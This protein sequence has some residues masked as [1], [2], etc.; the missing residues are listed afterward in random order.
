MR[1]HIRVLTILVCLGGITRLAAAANPFAGEWALTIPG[2]AAGWLGVQETNGRLEASMMWGWGSVEP[3]A[4]AKLE[5]GKL[6]LTRNH[7]IERTD[8]SGRKSKTT[9]TETITATVDGDT[10][11][12]VSVKPS[13]DGQREISSS[14][15]G[16]R[17]PPL[18]PA[19]DLSKVKFGPPIELFNGKD[20]S[21][22]R[23]TDPNAI[24][25]WNVKDGLLVNQV[26]QE[27]GKH[28]NYGNLR[29]DAEFQASVDDG[30]GL[31]G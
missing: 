14:F 11:K 31:A 26:V 15:S 19:P 6:I 5:D 29:T 23:L 17:Q 1:N 21:G 9:L 20:L 28:K 8:S 22:W 27:E 30:N 13:D 3:V 16:H 24:N 25:G 10:I 7:Q 4:S 18:P 12:L 2:G